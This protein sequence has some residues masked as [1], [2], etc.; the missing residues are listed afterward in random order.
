MEDLVANEYYFAGVC[1]CVCAVFLPACP[2]CCRGWGG[3]FASPETGRPP[4]RASQILLPW[5]AQFCYK[6]GCPLFDGRGLCVFVCLIVSPRA[7]SPLADS[8][9]RKR[10]EHVMG[11]QRQDA[12]TV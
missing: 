6:S 7:D 5:L 4:A 10:R 11:Q 2:L 1:V 12:R 9:S 3:Q 8:L